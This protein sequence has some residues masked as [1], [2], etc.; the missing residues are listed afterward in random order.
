M[1]TTVV[2]QSDIKRDWHH[3]DANGQIL[4]R[5]SSEIARKL[6]GK[7]KVNF[8]PNLDCGDYV[9]ITNAAKIEVTGRKEKQK[10]YHHHSTYPSGLKSLSYKQ[11]MEKDPTR[12][13][14]IAVKNMLPKNKL[15]AQ[16]LKRLKIFVDDNHPYQDKLK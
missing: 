13:I 8:S 11:M 2:K 5:L 1:K 9:L 3:L 6:I 10:M 14:T 15:R 4:G 12:I 16:R 7:D